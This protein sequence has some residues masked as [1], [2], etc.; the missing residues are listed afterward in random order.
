MNLQQAL[1]PERLFK[2]DTWASGDR[3]TA[4][5]LYALNLSISEA[6]YTSLHMLEIT[7]RNAIHYRMTA[8]HGP[9][10]FQNPAIIHARKQQDNIASAIQKL[11]ARATPNQIVAAVHLRL[12]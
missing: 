6:F 10:W 8:L 9:L 1:S 3:D 2:Y 4:L 5:R 12:H 7:L 11:G